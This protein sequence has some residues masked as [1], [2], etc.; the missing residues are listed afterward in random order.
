MFKFLAQAIILVFV[1]TIFVT[2]HAEP[3]TCM[4]LQPPDKQDYKVSSVLFNEQDKLVVCVYI[5]R[6]GSYG[7]QISASGSI[8]GEKGWK[9]DG[10]SGNWKCILDD[11]M[12][13]FEKD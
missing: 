5:N 6:V 12:C 1:S 7:G 11:K 8:S 2:A 10:D 3:I 13:K 9:K 4:G